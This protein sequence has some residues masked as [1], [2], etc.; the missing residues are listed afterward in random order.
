M[1]VTFNI[2]FNMELGGPFKKIS[3]QWGYS[4]YIDRNEEKQL[5]GYFS[6]PRY[7]F[8]WSIGEASWFPGKTTFMMKRLN[9]N[10]PHSEHNSFLV[11]ME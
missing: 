8:E 3:D 4:V 7:L 9:K 11:P 2:P 10:M 5:S 6:D 1:V